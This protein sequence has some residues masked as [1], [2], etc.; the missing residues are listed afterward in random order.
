MAQYFLVAIL[1]CTNTPAYP[2]TL[3]GARHFSE[4][5]LAL[6]LC[7]PVLGSH[8]TPSGDCGREYEGG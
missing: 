4:L 1:T 5:V 2:V 8:E 7:V 3:C 6:V